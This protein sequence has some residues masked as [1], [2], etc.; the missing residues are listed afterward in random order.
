[1]QRRVRD[2]SNPGWVSLKC[3]HSWPIIVA[4]LKGPAGTWLITHLSPSEG[5]PCA[6]Y[7]L[8][9]VYV[10]MCVKYEIR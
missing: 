4:N 10:S 5:W 7:A 8:M 3:K 9:C 2:S 6:V 1:M